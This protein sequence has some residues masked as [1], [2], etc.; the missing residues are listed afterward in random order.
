MHLRL[1]DLA[2]LLKVLKASL[3]QQ[4]KSHVDCHHCYCVL[5]SGPAALH[6][7]QTVSDAAVVLADDVNLIVGFKS[8]QPSWQKI[9]NGE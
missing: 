9:W 2:F 3:L 4:G 8:C 5:T 1:T 7:I 6:N